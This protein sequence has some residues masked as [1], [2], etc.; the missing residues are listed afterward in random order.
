MK[1]ECEIELQIQYAKCLRC[2]LRKDCVLGQEIVVN[3]EK[4][5]VEQY[6]ERDNEGQQWSNS[7]PV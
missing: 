7:D 5:A 2:I 1:D 3:W 4:Y 6:H